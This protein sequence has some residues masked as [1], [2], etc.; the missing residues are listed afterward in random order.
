MKLL[1]AKKLSHSFE[2]ELF[3]DIDLE[4]YPKE[5]IAIIGISGSGKSTLLHNL[6]TLLQPK[7]G[8]VEL[9]GKD[10]YSLSKKE[11]VKLRK[12]KI[13]MIFQ[14]HYLFKG[15]TAKENIEVATILA[16]ESFD[17]ALVQ[18]LNVQDVIEQKVTELSG[19]QQQRISIVRVLSKKPKI[20][21]ADEPTGN[22]DLNTAH[23]VM[24][25]FDDYIKE[26]EA[27]LVLVTH[28]QQL[29]DRCDHIFSLENQQLVKIK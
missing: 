21:F 24:D 2:Y 3:N 19:G 16:N 7:K 4:L 6:S 25:I 10:I 1:E 11:F 12:N 5:S 13:G 20:I 9:F 27:G 18:R 15:L 23:V 28:D 8:I 29:A 22:L 17:D 26:H 14:S